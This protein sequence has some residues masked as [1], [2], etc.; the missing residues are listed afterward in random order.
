[1]TG[2][3]TN[4]FLPMQHTNLYTYT[5][6]SHIFNSRSFMNFCNAENTIFTDAQSSDALI[7]SINTNGWKTRIF[8]LL[9]AFVFFSCSPQRLPQH[10]EFLHLTLFS[11]SALVT[12]VNFM[13]SHTTFIYSISSSIPLGPLSANFNLSIF[14]MIFHNPS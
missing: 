7:P 13:S 3:L 11:A 2:Q 10:I 4:I 9:S 5:V 8:L 6:L 1:M 12:P 14:Q